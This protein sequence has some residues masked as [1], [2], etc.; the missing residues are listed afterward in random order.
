MDDD[1]A[2]YEAELRRITTSGLHEIDDEQRLLNRAVYADIADI[3][4]FDDV[5][6]VSDCDLIYRFLIAKRWDTPEA[7]AALRAYN[8][9]REEMGLNGILWEPVN[10]AVAAIMPCFRGTDNFGHPIFY[11]RPDPA[12]MGVMLVTYP[13]E[14]I[15]RAHFVMMEQGRRLCK[16]MGTDRVSCVLDMAMLNM[17]LVTNPT[18]VGFLKEMSHLDQTYF[19]EHIRSLLITNH[20]WTFS[21]MYKVIRPLLDERVQ[22]KI[23]F[24]SSGAQRADDMA[25]WVD[26]ARVPAAYGGEAEDRAGHGFPELD[27]VKAQYAVGAPPYHAAREAFLRTRRSRWRRFFRWCR[28]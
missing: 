13:R 11:D 10:D 9:W 5:H 19:P 17:A 25:V 6:K 27:L 23:K 21:I 28:V 24:I 22:K 3:L 14:D 26:L 8:D 7:A 20:G 18:A 12:K 15:L 4:P 16:I 1:D 2:F